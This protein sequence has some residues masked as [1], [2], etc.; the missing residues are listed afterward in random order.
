L[1]FP[2]KERERRTESRAE[3]AEQRE[4]EHR[5]HWDRPT[6]LQAGHEKEIIKSY[7]KNVKRKKG[8]TSKGESISHPTLT[9]KFVWEYNI[10]ITIE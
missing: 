9:P 7:N 6:L 1:V 4:K 3:R 10:I 2:K 8:S 5:F